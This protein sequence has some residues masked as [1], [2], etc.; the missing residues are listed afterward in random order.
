MGI[1]VIGTVADLWENKMS[2]AA[3][4]K[5][6]I[7]EPDQVLA[8]SLRVAIRIVG[9]EAVVSADAESALKL[10]FGG[11]RFHAALVAYTQPRLSGV[12]FCAMSRSMDDP[13]NI[14]IVGMSSDHRVREEMLGAGADDFLT[15]PFSMARLRDA[16]G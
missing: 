2:E 10:L 11:A 14:R 7:V 4:L 15:K 1:A 5:V 13:D 3:E 6:L 12:D 16:L 9:F 8:S